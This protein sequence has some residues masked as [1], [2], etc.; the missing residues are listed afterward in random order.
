MRILIC[1][2][3]GLADLFDPFELVVYLNEYVKFPCTGLTEHVRHGSLKLELELTQ[4]KILDVTIISRGAPYGCPASC[5]QSFS[6]QSIEDTP[7]TAGWQSDSVWVQPSWL[8]L[9]W[10]Y[11]QALQTQIQPLRKAVICENQSWSR[12]LFANI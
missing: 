1:R 8:L 9:P 10:H 5:Q 6:I 2:D 3:L 4:S 12:R 7:S 11:Q